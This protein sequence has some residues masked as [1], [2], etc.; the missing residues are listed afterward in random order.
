MELEITIG[1]SRSQK[2]IWQELT[3]K[4]WRDLLSKRP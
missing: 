2:K 3:R 1:K 4:R